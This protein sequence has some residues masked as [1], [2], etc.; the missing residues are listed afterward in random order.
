M[1][2]TSK[3]VTKERGTIGFEAELRLN[4][5]NGLICDPTWSSG[6][7]HAPFMTAEKFVE[8]HGGKLGVISIH[9][10]ESHSTIRRHLEALRHHALSA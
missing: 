3:N 6:P 1:P 10:Q 7:A 5:S 2:A 9:G 8:S 4:L